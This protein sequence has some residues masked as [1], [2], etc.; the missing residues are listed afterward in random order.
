MQK[1]ILI[2]D[3]E[4]AD[5][6][7]ETA[8]LT[9]LCNKDDPHIVTCEHDFRKAFHETHRWSIIIINFQVTAL[10]N[11]PEDVCSAYVLEI[12][13]FQKPSCIFVGITTNNSQREILQRHGFKLSQKIYPIEDLRV[14]LELPPKNNVTI[15]D[16]KNLVCTEYALSPDV[17]IKKTRKRVIVEPRQV[18]LYLCKLF[19]KESLKSI[20]QYFNKKDHTT[21]RYSYLKI[22]DLMDVDED[23][24]KKIRKLEIALETL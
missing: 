14:L 12:K 7:T 17:L 13:T 4:L 8:Y 18:A 15:D 3:P 19:V 21:V 5:S 23:F 10:L 16:V 2:F 9:M 1:Q 11:M 24:R 22:K 6:N 20:G